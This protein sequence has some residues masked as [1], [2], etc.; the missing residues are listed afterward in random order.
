MQR[1]LIEC[2]FMPRLK[3]IRER[4]PEKKTHPKDSFVPVS[5]HYEPFAEGYRLH[6]W[7]DGEG[8]RRVKVEANVGEGPVCERPVRRKQ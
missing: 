7:L 8:N 1:S 3:D 2:D 4:L 5:E 6:V